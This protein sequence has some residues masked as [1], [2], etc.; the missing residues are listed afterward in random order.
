MALP[1]GRFCRGGKLW[2]RKDVPV[3]LREIIGQTSLQQTLGTGDV[4]RARVLFH[5]VMRGFEARIADAKD[6][7]ANEKP[8]GSNPYMF[9]LTP[10]QLD[11]NPQRLEAYAQYLEMKP[12]NQALAATRRMER[13][14]VEAG[15]ATPEKDPVSLD[16]L[17]ERWIK[18]KQPKPNSQNEFVRAKNLFKTLNT[19]KAIAEYTPAD[20]RKYKDRVLELTAPNGKPLT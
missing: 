5:E 15:L 2:A 14:L 7:L 20:V 3:P 12:E 8:T 19:D 13:K 11:F 9:T 18:E 1:R 4:N 6:R 16:E 17:F 10:E